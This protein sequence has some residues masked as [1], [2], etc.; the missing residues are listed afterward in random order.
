MKTH[1]KFYKKPTP[2]RSKYRR[3]AQFNR[4]LQLRRHEKSGSGQGQERRGS[5]GRGCRHVVDIIR[6]DGVDFHTGRTVVSVKVG[7]GG[8]TS[9]FTQ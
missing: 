9:R 5:A 7:K 4:V 3:L 2:P 1:G 6:A 8:Q